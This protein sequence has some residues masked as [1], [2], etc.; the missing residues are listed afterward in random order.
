M[1]YTIGTELKKMNDTLKKI[2]KELEHARL[3]RL[4]ENKTR[5]KNHESQAKLNDDP[6]TVVK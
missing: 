5:Q 3:D 6:R 4:E 1:D 2:H